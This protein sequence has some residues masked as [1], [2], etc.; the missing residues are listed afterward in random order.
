VAGMTRGTPDYSP[1]TL[2]SDTVY[3]WRVDQFDGLATHK[4]DVWS[5]RTLPEIPI[6]DPSLVGWWKLDADSG[7]VAVDWSG[8]GNH[9]ILQGDPQWAPGQVGGALEFDGSGD[10]VDC[11]DLPSLTITGDITLM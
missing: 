7:T 11:G 4:G 8:N 2:A 6:T 9:G 3:Y 1:G 10:Y 5:F